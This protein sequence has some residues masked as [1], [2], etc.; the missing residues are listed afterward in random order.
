MGR[1]EIMLINKK[2]LFLFL[3]VLSGLMILYFLTKF[4]LGSIDV[5]SIAD[6]LRSLGPW[7]ALLGGG[8][9]ILQTFF[10]FMPFLLLA[11]ANVLVFGLWEGF[12]VNWL[13]AVLASVLM[14]YMA[15]TFGREWAMRK[16]NNFPKI[17]SVSRYF[18]Q[19]GFKTVLFLRLFPVIPPAAV[20]LAAGLSGIEARAYLWGTALGKLPAIF[21]QSMIGND[22]FHFADNKVR[23]L[24]ITA[25]FGLILLI[26]MRVVKK[27]WK[28][29]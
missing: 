1:G 13:S 21:V 26:G 28:L 16:M 2:R 6:A 3:V 20:N 10:P 27:K 8:L 14:F 11:G 19:N 17:Q 24:L 4:R 9:I 15:R 22:L 23:L 18:Q 29:S 7:A 12:V 25:G 5:E